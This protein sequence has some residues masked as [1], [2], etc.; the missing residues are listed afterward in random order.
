[1]QHQLKDCVCLAGARS[2]DANAEASPAHMFRAGH[3]AFVAD[4]AA[5]FPA[6]AAGIESYVN[7]AASLQRAAWPFFVGSA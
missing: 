6:D 3:A 4:L 2:H 1:M 5:R 7:Q